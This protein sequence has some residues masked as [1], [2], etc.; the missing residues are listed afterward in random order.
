MTLSDNGNSRTNVLF[1]WLGVLVA[2]TTSFIFIAGSRMLVARQLSAVP[3]ETGADNLQELM[4][5]DAACFWSLRPN[6]KNQQVAERLA[7]D[8]GTLSSYSYST[9][10]LGFRGPSLSTTDGPFRILAVGDSTTF[11]QHLNDEETWPAQLQ[12]RLDPSREHIEIINAGVIGASS[13]QGL[14]FLATRGLALHPDMVTV[15]F[16]FNDWARAEV[17][18]RERARLYKRRGIWGMLLHLWDMKS[19]DTGDVLVDRAT[20]GEYLDHMLAIAELCA[21]RDIPLL[22]LLWPSP[23]E[24]EDPV[25]QSSRERPLLLGACQLS[26]AECVDLLPAFRRSETPTHLDIIHATA[27]GC[28]IVAETLAAHIRPKLPPE[29]VATP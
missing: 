3:L 26:S 11:G 24:V 4:Q 15:T 9:N 19:S 25:G 22:F 27:H 18:D 1:F 14:S 8:D 12:Q 21:E 10:E 7:N 16:G 28:A 20:P 13:F 29:A 6:L 17:S 23:F 2:L 5:V